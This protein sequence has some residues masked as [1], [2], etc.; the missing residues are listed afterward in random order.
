M[1]LFTTK[2]KWPLASVRF[3]YWRGRKRVVD[4]DD[5]RAE[6]HV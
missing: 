6:T 2:V 4:E 1:K 5:R 3:V